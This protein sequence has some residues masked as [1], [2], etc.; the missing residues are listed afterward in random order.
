VDVVLW[1]LALQA[2][3]GAFDTLYF[4]EW[5][6]RL[7]ARIPTTADELRLHAGRDFVYAALFGTLPFVAWHG[8]LVIVLAILLATEIVVTLAD[9]VVEERV[10]KPMGGVFAGERV[11]HALM[12]IVYGAMLGYFVP[13]LAD[14]W[15]EPT[16]WVIAPAPIPAVFAA[17]LALMAAGTFVSGLRDTYAL[18]DMKH[19][20]WPWQR[21][22]P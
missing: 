13:V 22:T 5:R 9:F 12:G 7:V 11:T 3:L 14:W 17:V 15:R 20:S 4:H 18:I 1:L 8:A 10:R 19:G 16:G 6:A 21:V 2:A